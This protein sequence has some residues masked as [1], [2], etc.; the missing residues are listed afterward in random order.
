M[1]TTL[2][3]SWSTTFKLQLKKRQK[4]HFWQ[5]RLVFLSILAPFQRIN[6]ATFYANS[7]F[8]LCLTKKNKIT[9]VSF[10]MFSHCCCSSESFKVGHQNF[11]GDTTGHVDHMATSIC[12]LAEHLNKSASWQWSCFD[13]TPLKHSRYINTMAFLALGGKYSG[14]K[15]VFRGSFH[16]TY[17]SIFKY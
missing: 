17:S 9:T 10:V 3:T 15:P 13:P 5:N 8:V 2:H 11:E 7:L 14:T 12:A 6:S 16:L 1:W 4:L